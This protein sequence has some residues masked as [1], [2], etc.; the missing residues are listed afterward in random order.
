[1]THTYTIEYYQSGKRRTK[2][3]RRRVCRACGQVFHSAETVLTDP[4]TGG[5]AA[6]AD[7]LP[8]G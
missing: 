4:P 6:D 5:K 8:M 3:K 1:V 2:V 7:R